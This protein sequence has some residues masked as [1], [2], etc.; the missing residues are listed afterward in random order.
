MRKLLIAMVLSASITLLAPGLASASKKS[1]Q[2]LAE[3]ATLQQID[4]PDVFVELPIGD[5][6]ESP[7]SYACEGTIGTANDTAL[8]AP[9]GSSGFKL[10]ESQGYAIINSEVA[11]LRNTAAAKK[12]LDAYQDEAA[13]EA[14]TRTVF[15]KFLTQP[16]VTTEVDV[17]SFSPELDDKGSKKVIK[18]GDE[19]VGVSVGARR[20][21]E[22]GEP[23]FLEAIVVI[24]RV[25]RSTFHLTLITTGVAPVDDVQAMTQAVVKRLD[26][27]R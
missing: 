3:K 22:G 17:G 1:D 6:D 15:A 24:G 12:A 20:F 7:F 5:E 19:F 16:G 25:G 21:V 23:Q 14:C 8:A 10:D 13:A 27:A 11:L 9:H 18:G 26:S 4:V 2:K